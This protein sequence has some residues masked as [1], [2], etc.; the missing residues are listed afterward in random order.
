MKKS[1]KKNK[2]N[3][4][5]YILGIVLVFSIV[6][7]LTYKKDPAFD[8]SE[9]LLDQ[10]QPVV[11]EAYKNEGNIFP[12]I[13]LQG[14]NIKSVNEEIVDL[15]DSKGKNSNFSYT[16]NISKDTLSLLIAKYTYVDN[17]KYINYTSYN[18]DLNTMTRLTDEQIYQ[19]FEIDEETLRVFVSSKF[20]NMYADMLDKN[21][22]DGNKCDF[23]CFIYNCN[24]QDYLEDNVFYI[25]DNHL[26]LYK[27]F[28]TNTKYN[29][30]DYFNDESYSF[31]VK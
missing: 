10:S 28:N 14:E 20:L 22:I 4:I 25:E 16:Y 30:A 6:V 7:L 24:F 29:Y 1:K 5:Y 12:V 23:D 11:Y 2:N 9:L 8:T 3:Y 27:F 17:V 21:Y 26:I 15:Y 19:M 18:I 31:I 13:N